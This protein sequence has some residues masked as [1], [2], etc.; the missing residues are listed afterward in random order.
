[1]RKCEYFGDVQMG[2]CVAVQMCELDVQWVDLA[3]VRIGI[4]ADL[5]N[6]LI[7]MLT[8][9]E[10]LLIKRTLQNCNHK[11]AYLHIE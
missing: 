11:S 7:Q 10:M 1:M 5:E 4:D 8:I 9:V 6:V 2:R 3:D